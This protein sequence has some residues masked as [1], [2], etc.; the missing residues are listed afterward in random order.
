MEKNMKAL[1]AAVLSLL[2][3]AAL[4][5]DTSKKP[6]ARVLAKVNGD[7]VTAQE[8]LDAFSNRHSGHARF[9]GGPI[10]AR[11]FL[12]MVVDERLFIQEGY[13]I[14]LDQDAEVVKTLADRE[15]ARASEVLLRGEIDEKA[16][17]PANEVRAVW[18]ELN[19]VVQ[20]RQIILDSREDAESV[21]RAILQGA[22][23]DALARNCSRGPSRSHGGMI[24]P[25]WGQAEPAWER[26]VFALGDGE[27]SPVIETS[28]GY[29]VVLVMARR[30]AVRPPFEKV[31]EQIEATLQERKLD[32]RKRAF[33]DELWAKYHV[34]LAPLPASPDGVVA[35]WDGG[36]K[37]TLGEALSADELR[38]FA[39]ESPRH[40]QVEIESRI[41]T[42][43]NT[44]LVALEAKAR[45]IEQLP[46]VAEALEHDRDMLVEAALFRDHVMKEV[47]ASDDD[48]RK[49]YDEHKSDFL[50]AEQRHVAQILLSNEKD[51]K[52]V[53]DKLAAGADFDT[54][55]R[56]QSRDFVTA[57]S[58]GDLGW[59]TSEKVPGAFKEV[60]T[61]AAGKIAHPAQSPAGWHVIK[62][63]DV[64]PKR[65]QAFDE[66]ADQAQMKSVELKRRNAQKFWLTKLRAAA[67]VEI[68]DT[69]I[70]EFVA[71]YQFKGEAP[72]QHGTK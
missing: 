30:D 28:Y 3:P 8:L 36:G 44:P 71:A 12:D 17:P 19:F 63:L 26:V 32:E 59:I 62:V 13:N 70:K 1:L 56:K 20:A 58:G 34:V 54:L 22:D 11:R 72:P 42:T 9:L 6:D 43:V 65:Q 52:A 53:Y 39:K 25:S 15:K 24:V 35:T 10:E 57:G 23:F 50:A 55:A 48:A 38:A 5:A 41:R 16:M 49:Y 29:E 61:L 60:L 67:K 45:K 14:G 69:A 40:A 7:P 4:T 68:D 66:V 64:K 37:A 2:L 46:E 33:S 21:R 47:V 27:L 31:R 51:A 18:Q